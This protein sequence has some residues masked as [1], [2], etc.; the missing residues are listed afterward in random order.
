MRSDYSIFWVANF[1]RMHR[2]QLGYDFYHKHWYS[3]QWWLR[4]M[5]SSVILLWFKRFWWKKFCRKL[6]NSLRISNK[7]RT[8]KLWDLPHFTL[9]RTLR[10]SN[11]RMW[12][13][14][15][16]QTGFP[17]SAQFT[18]THPLPRASSHTRHYSWTTDGAR[19]WWWLQFWHA[20]LCVF[21]FMS[22]RLL[23]AFLYIAFPLNM[24]IFWYHHQ[25]ATQRTTECY[26]FSL[27]AKSS[28]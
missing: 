24:T 2:G 17:S 11:Q 18:L 4:E 7:E 28:I 13:R 26:L 27:C 22:C 12:C 20:R 25:Q 23:Q 5:T 3:L 6:F 9:L 16:E 19:W 15:I 21:L 1:S 8:T 10:Y 14:N